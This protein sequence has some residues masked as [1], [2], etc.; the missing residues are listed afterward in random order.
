WSYLPEVYKS[1][2]EKREAAAQKGDEG[3]A[4]ATGAPSNTQ[5]PDAKKAGP[6]VTDA[7]PKAEARQKTAIAGAGVRKDA[8]ASVLPL[9][10]AVFLVVMLAIA[11]VLP[12]VGNLLN[13]PQGIIGLLILFWGLHQAWRLT[14]KVTL[15]FRGPF[16]VGRAGTAAA[17]VP[18]HG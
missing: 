4:A 7:G 18:T 6:V 1:F 15:N 5:A 3:G 12:I 16:R 8:P 14:R 10:I 11:Y 17:E 2:K 13:M 9:G